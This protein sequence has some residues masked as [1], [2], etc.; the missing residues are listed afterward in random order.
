MVEVLFIFQ[1]EHPE[2]LTII[3]KMTPWDKEC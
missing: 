2:S 1:D 3:P